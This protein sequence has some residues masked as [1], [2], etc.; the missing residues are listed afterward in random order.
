MPFPG[1]HTDWERRTTSPCLGQKQQEH[2]RWGR[3][4]TLPLPGEEKRLAASKA[5]RHEERLE[6][7]KEQ[8]WMA[9]VNI[10]REDQKYG[11]KGAKM[12]GRQ[13]RTNKTKDEFGGENQQLPFHGIFG[14]GE[15]KAVITPAT[16][17]ADMTRR[18][19]LD[20]MRT[21]LGLKKC[22][23]NN[24]DYQQLFVLFVF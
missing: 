10:W 9:R 15:A 19:S 4:R 22:V 13:R 1:K 6:A 14:R 21:P 3:P 17:S 16:M 11:G 20:E 24:Q 18:A 7:P 8:K 23:K 5:H 12:A 2:N